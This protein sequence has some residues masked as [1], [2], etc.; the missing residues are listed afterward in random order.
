MTEKTRILVIEDNNFVRMQIVT[1]LKRAEELSCEIIEAENGEQGLE[2]IDDT[3]DIAVVDVRMQP[4]DGFEFIRHI[5]GEGNECPVIL[6][7][8]DSN[9][10]L[11]NEANKWNVSAVLKKPIQKDRLIKAVNRTLQI[12]ARAS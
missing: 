8:G 11:L 12:K 1:F 7:T 4:I 9:P 6:A 2:I 5:R 10:E 3:I